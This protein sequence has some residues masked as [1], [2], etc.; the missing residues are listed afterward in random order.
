MEYR[1]FAWSDGKQSRYNVEQKGYMSEAQHLLWQG[2]R[3]DTAG[4]DEG[5]SWWIGAYPFLRVGRKT[6]CCEAE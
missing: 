6:K 1:F 2:A 4:Q 3:G 5:E